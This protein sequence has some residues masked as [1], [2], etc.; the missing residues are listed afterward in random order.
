MSGG[1]PLS[2]TFHPGRGINWA[3][4]RFGGRCAVVDGSRRFSFLDIQ[5]RSNRIA[6]ALLAHGL[7]AESR[8]AKL[9]NNR[10]EIIEI[11]FG[12]DKAGGASI[13]LHARNSADEHVHMLEDSEAEFLFVDEDHR[14]QVPALRDA[15]GRLRCIVGV[16]W[17]EEGVEPYERWIE[18]ASDA[19]P[20][21]EVTLDGLFHLHYTSGTTGR[22]KAAMNTHRTHRAW[23]ANFF[24]NMDNRYGVEDAMVHAGPMTHASYNF[25]EITFLRGARNIILNRFDPELFL[26]T[27]ERERGTTT[28]LVS[29]MILMLLEC[30]RLER[31]G[32][33]SLRTINYG[34]AP[35]SEEN[36]RRAIEAF[37]PIFRQVYGLTEARQPITILQPWEHIPNGALQERRRLASCGRPALGVTFALLDE[38]DRPV[39]RGGVGEI[40]VRGDYAMTGYWKDPEATAGTMRGGWV[41][42]GDLATEDEDG[43]IYIV[44]RKKDMIISGGYNIYPAEIERVLC[45][46][47]G[48]AEAM[49][50]GVPDDRW[51]EAVK[52]LIV[53]RPG[54]RADAAEFVRFTRDRIASYKKPK[55]VEVVDEL[56]KNMRGKILRREIRD[57]H[58]QGKS[59]RVN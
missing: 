48:V 19:D 56:P 11:G 47:P 28:Y 42:T 2:E 27:V 34:A 46:H 13:N 36:L 20:G 40:C 38:E 57:R 10:A 29:T 59:R 58:W 54:E 7:S 41:H 17:E 9:M 39:S 49:V 33:S 53:M 21:I 32:L 5:R 6:N 37:G 14:G 31:A 51:G 3:G 8:V 25:T 24:M 35:I 22:P 50:I 45:L 44:D 18:R 4:R 23:M 55:Y 26:D 12:A 30:G 16:G 1:I 43:F 52:A 15:C